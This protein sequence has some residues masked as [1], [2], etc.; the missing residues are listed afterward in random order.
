MN[1]N[2][3]TKNRS[4]YWFDQD[5]RLDDNPALA[6]AASGADELLCLYIDDEA[7]FAADRFGTPRTGDIRA[8]FIDASL[9]TLAHGLAASG[10]RLLRLG[11]DPVALIAELIARHKINR[12]VRSR[13][14]GWYETI[15]WSELES[16]HPAVDFVE[17]DGYTLFDESQLMRAEDFPPTFSRFRRHV[18]KNLEVP[19]PAGET[20]LP[21]PIEAGAPGLADKPETPAPEAVFAGGEAAAIAHLEAYFGSPAP[22]SYKLTRNE[23]DGWNNSSKFSPWLAA[24]CVSVRRV[25]RWIKDYEN[26]NGAN[27]STYWLYFELLWR[28]F[29]QWYAKTHGPRLFLPGGL[30]DDLPDTGF[31]AGRFESW[32]HGQTPWPLVNA[33]MS[34]LNRTGYLSNR[35]RQIVASSLVYDLG[36]DWRA[37][38]GYFESR[39]VDYDVAS[40]WGNWQYIAGVGADARGGRHFNIARQARQYDPDA[41]YANK[42]QRMAEPLAAPAA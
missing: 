40:N 17:V 14:F 33:C 20:R 26:D 19:P 10:Q 41:S 4:L 27:D 25:Y 42:W 29:F 7:R 3:T 15:Q 2:S 31:N 22:S 32:C 1:S 37:G 11:G 30:N 6:R 36:I 28:E 35:A 12:V 9:E 16:S 34:Q 24:G 18:E 21:P 13:H 5:L 38:A 8:A 23:L 39:L